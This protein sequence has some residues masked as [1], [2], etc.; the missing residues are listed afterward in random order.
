MQSG[1]AKSSTNENAV[2]SRRSEVGSSRIALIQPC[3]SPRSRGKINA[4]RLITASHSGDTAKRTARTFSFSSRNRI[5]MARSDSLIGESFA[6]RFTPPYPR[7]MTRARSAMLLLAAA[8][9]LPVVAA[10]SG[11]AAP[12]T[13]TV[14]AKVEVGGQPCGVVGTPTGVWIADYAGNRL[15]RIDPATGA[16]AGEIGGVRQTCEITFA[17]GA[18]WAPSR[19]GILYRVDPIAR[20]ITARVQVGGEL[21]D[22]VASAGSVWVVSY[23]GRSVIR[24]NPRTNRVARRIALPGARGGGSGITA[25]GGAVWAGQTQGSAVFR[26]D[27]RTNRVVVVRTGKVGPAWFSSSGDAVWFS[28]IYDNTVMRLDPAT[29]KVTA[30]IPVQSTPVNLEAIGRDVWVPNDTSNVVTRIDRETG[31]VLEVIDT[32]RNPAVVA[33]WNGDAWVTMFDAGE[34]WQLRPPAR[35]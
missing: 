21:D 5:G 31:Q 15:V 34:V 24:V 3:W 2:S 4:L 6:S 13:S 20:K 22:V 19:T 11:L 30:T 8:L 33:G 14:I 35:S 7:R 27:P 29:R 26:I 10:A 17:R 25:A 28:N 16:V 32:A 23:G 18:V 9:L 12:G 1:T